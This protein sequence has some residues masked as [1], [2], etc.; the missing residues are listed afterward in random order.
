MA[1]VGAL[2]KKH[3]RVLLAGVQFLTTIPVRMRTAPTSAEVGATLLYYPVIGLL[4]GGFLVVGATLLAGAPA[5]LSAA[6]ILVLW[7]VIT[8]GLHLDGLADSAD[9]WHG[10]RGDVPR[11]LAIMKDPHCGP[12]AVVWLVLVLVVKYGALVAACGQH[13]TVA[14]LLAPCLAR[15]AVVLLLLT[16]PYVRPGGLGIALAEQ[17]PR[18]GVI[19]VCASTAVLVVSCFGAV[20]VVMMIVAATALLGLRALMQ[21]H[22]GGTTGDT[23][24]G[25]IELIEAAVVVAGAL[26]G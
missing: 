12:A 7:V 14:L 15:V 11:M 20:G 1:V 6:L 26:W 10:G 9:A 13:L 25:L 21:R 18:T 24:G 17:H 22:L 8:G 2:A 4:I 16:T 19:A 23:A 5:E 3:W